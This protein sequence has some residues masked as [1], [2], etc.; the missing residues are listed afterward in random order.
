MSAEKS[1]SRPDGTAA[2][3][4]RLLDLERQAAAAAKIQGD[5]K[6]PEFRKFPLPDVSLLG[7]DGADGT[8][9]GNKACH[10][11]QPASNDIGREQPRSNQSCIG[12]LRIREGRLFLL[13]TPTDL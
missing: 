2:L 4:P 11:A 12:P 1:S 13:Y 3:P 6:E 5:L 7:T 8:G 9:R 10:T